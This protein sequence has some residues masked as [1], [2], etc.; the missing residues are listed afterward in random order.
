[1]AIKRIPETTL[2]RPPFSKTYVYR[3]K[4]KAYIAD[5]LGLT[6]SKPTKYMFE[7]PFKLKIDLALNL[8]TTPLAVVA[9]PADELADEPADE[10]LTVV[11]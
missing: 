8:G 3:L 7:I 10:P 5:T 1:M 6:E 4:S 2:S 11:A 9:E